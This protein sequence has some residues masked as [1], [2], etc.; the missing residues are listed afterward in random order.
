[1]QLFDFR[2]RN[3]P[4]RLQV[5]LPSLVVILAFAV[6]VGMTW[7][8]EQTRG[9]AAA[10]AEVARNA[11]W[12]IT[13]AQTNFERAR[14]TGA[15]FLV[16][17]DA[18]LVTPTLGGL[19]ATLAR[20]D[21]VTRSDVASDVTELRR[22]TAVFR[23]DFV[24][25]VARVNELGLTEADG[26]QGRVGTAAEKLEAALAALA[27]PEHEAPANLR[28]TLLEIRKNEKDFL[29]Q[30]N[31]LFA[32]QMASLNGDF[33]EALDGAALDDASRA[34]LEGLLA[35]YL[36]QFRALADGM[37]ELRTF[38]RPCVAK[39]LDYR[40]NLRHARTHCGNR[41]WRSRLGQILQRVWPNGR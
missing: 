14:S 13:E 23:S 5:I 31:S 26:L 10:E 2:L 29:L 37:V 8:A 7:R 21:E 38:A 15:Y 4:I 24:A 9:R 25:M 39:L 33:S 11:A 1:M 30:N 16:E 41:A 36:R 28:I 32:A 22:L 19:D 35:T 27:T 6:V 18:S 40:R 12:R 34:T 20:L 3:I 17:R